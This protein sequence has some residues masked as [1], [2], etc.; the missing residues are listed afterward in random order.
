MRGRGPHLPP[1][2]QVVQY[3][4]EPGYVVFTMHSPK[5]VRVRMGKTWVADSTQAVLLYE[6]DHLPAYYFPLADVRTDLFRDSDKR[7]DCPFKGPAV[8]QSFESEGRRVADALWRYASPPEGSPDLRGYC[9]FVW[10][11]VDHWYEEDEE[12]FVHARDPFRRV[13][14]LPTARRVRVEFEG[15]VVAESWR[16]VFLFETGLPTRHYLP[17]EDVRR[18]FLR[19]SR[20]QTRCPYKGIAHYYDLQV[21]ATLLQ[22]RVWYYPDPVAEAQRVKGLVAFPAEFMDVFVDDVLQPRPETTFLR[23][24]A[25]IGPR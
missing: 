24:Y 4:F 19:Q 9:S 14:C 15:V 1:L 8:F 16:S 22:D 21:G 25:Q 6:S 12:I 17:L 18:E 20:C 23:G 7:I 3:P 10:D 11:Q 13:D 2:D 5:R